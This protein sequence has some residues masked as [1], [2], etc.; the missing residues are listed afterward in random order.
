MSY[1]SETFSKN[2]LSLSSPQPAVCQL[3]GK[4]SL[5]LKFFANQSGSRGVSLFDLP[6][7]NSLDKARNFLAQHN[8][9]APLR[10]SETIIR[11]LSSA[12]EQLH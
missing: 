2:P 9:H 5:H 11:T 7:V 8:S 6:P 3:N 12:A 10:R 4:A 1:A